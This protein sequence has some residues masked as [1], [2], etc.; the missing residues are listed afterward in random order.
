MS[1]AYILFM[2]SELNTMESEYYFVYQK[3]Y[4]NSIITDVL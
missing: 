3:N 2:I 1:I 4:N